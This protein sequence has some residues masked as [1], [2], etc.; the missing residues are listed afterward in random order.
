MEA[1][2]FMSSCF[3]YILINTYDKLSLS[4]ITRSYF[5]VKLRNVL[6]DKRRLIMGYAFEIITQ[7]QAE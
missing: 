6:G 5:L 1:T 7:E 2:D 3:F 4:G